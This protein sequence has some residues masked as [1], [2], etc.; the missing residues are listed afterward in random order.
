MTLDD[1]SCDVILEQAAGPGS[2]ANEPTGPKMPTSAKTDDSMIDMLNRN[3]AATKISDGGDG[4]GNK[5]LPKSRNRGHTYT[6]SI[7]IQSEASAYIYDA[8]T[9][10]GR[11]TIHSGDEHKEDRESGDLN[12]SGMSINGRSTV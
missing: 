4:S 9:M 12:L 10:N 3:E 11:N 5:K 1:P 7:Y 2:V 8:N 6:S